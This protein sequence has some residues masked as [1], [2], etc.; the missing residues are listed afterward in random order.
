MKEQFSPTPPIH[1]EID[2]SPEREGLDL[3]YKELVEGL[4][5]IEK[6]RQEEHLSPEE[7]DQRTK[8]LIEEWKG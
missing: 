4:M 5:G 3:D 1:R 8:E 7:V 6:Q 2:F